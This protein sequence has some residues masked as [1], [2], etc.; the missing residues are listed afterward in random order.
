MDSFLL[1]DLLTM[2]SLSFHLFL[3]LVLLSLVG[4]LNKMSENAFFKVSLDSNSPFD[5]T[6]EGRGN[7]ELLRKNGNGNVGVVQDVLYG[8]AKRD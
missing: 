6:K 3:L 1:A 7:R 2:N 4:S 5:L 8:Q